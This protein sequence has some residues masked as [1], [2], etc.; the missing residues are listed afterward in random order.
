MH[1]GSGG[2]GVSIFHHGVA[3]GHIFWLLYNRGGA[4]GDERK[5]ENN[6]FLIKSSCVCAILLPVPVLA[7][8]HTVVFYAQ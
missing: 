5:N 2:A 4:E 3:S 8:I 6:E 1:V 7:S